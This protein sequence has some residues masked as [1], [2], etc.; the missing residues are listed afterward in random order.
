[1]HEATGLTLQFDSVYARIGRYGP[2]V[3]FRGARVLPETGDEPLVTA[4]SGRVSLSIPRSLWY[5]RLEVGRVSFVR[6]RLSFVIT[7]DGHIRLV[8]QSA[9]QRRDEEHAPM[10]LDRLPRGHYAV[11]D[12]TLDVLDL[13]SRQGRFQLTGANVDVRRKGDE[14]TVVG[15][16]E[17]PGHL[18]SFIDFEGQAN[19]DLEDTA[20]VAWR[21]HVDA[22]DLDLEQWAATLPDSFRVPAAGHGSIR[23]SA[24]GAGR[25]VTSL[26]VQPALTDLRLAG[27]TEEFTRVAGDI[28]VQR[29]ATTVSLEAAGF[30]LS[31]AG[32]PWRPTSLEA[33]LTRKDGR[34]A[35]VAARA[36]YLRIENLA[37]LAAAMPQG[38]LRERIATLAPRGELF[39]LNLAVTDVG[40][41][42]TSGHHGPPA[43]HGHRLWPAR[44]GSRHHRLRR[45]LSKAAAPA[46]SST[47]RHA[48]P[49]STGHN[50]GA[51]RLR[52]CVPTGASSGSVSAM[53]CA[54][55]S[56]TRSRTAATAAREARSGCCSGPA[57]C[58]LW[59]SARRPRTST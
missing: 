11:D 27:S 57:S 1:M 49:P 20:K 52:S 39:G 4:A 2:E 45:R 12:A 25:E 43:L 30:E 32:R 31:R 23:V 40:G 51:H 18:G 3:V 14:I 34:I 54:S 36:D 9:L 5:R 33:R 44:Q 37:V 13:R 16:V 46:A 59:M 41:R 21:A 42:R 29:D 47:S 10:T 7:S 19:G 24:R 58:R 15:R 56:T 17:L 53:A 28:R 22:R 55:G 26:R 8:G 35:A 50:N 38:A 6:P 48:T